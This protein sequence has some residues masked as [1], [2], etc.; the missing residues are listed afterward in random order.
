MN[1]RVHHAAEFLG[2]ETES[3]I[4]IKDHSINWNLT[5]PCSHSHNWADNGIKN[6]NLIWK[7]TMLRK[8]GSPRLRDYGMKHDAEL[9]SRI[10]PN[11]K[12]SP[13]ENL[14]GDTIDL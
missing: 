11:N 14:T 3:V 12:K 2:E 1:M 10:S 7:S 5:E 9:L 4:R 13:L 8:G 6:N